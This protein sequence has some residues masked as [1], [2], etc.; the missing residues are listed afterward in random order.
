MGDL[1]PT[2]EIE[3]PWRIELAV[4]AV[5]ILQAIERGVEYSGTDENPHA[6]QRMTADPIC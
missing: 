6:G 4:V 3:Q 2:I 1:V 5:M